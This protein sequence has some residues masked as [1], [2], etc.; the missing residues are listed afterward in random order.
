MPAAVCTLVWAFA[1][2][3]ALGT[4]AAATAPLSG[5]QGMCGGNHGAIATC[6]AAR[7]HLRR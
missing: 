4:V 6:A 1:G 2:E 5:V 3:R 7:T